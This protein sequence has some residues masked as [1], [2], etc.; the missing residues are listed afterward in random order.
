MNLDRDSLLSLAEKPLKPK[1]VNTA[2][3]TVYTPLMNAKEL[4][5]FLD[6]I[7]GKNSQEMLHLV[8]DQYGQRV[9]KESDVE[10]VER[11]PAA[12]TVPVTR[13]FREANGLVPKAS[14]SIDDSP[15]GSP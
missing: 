13:A 4:A 3:G 14:V 6:A 12:F 10:H 7:D 1:Q 9:F 5:V 8:V 2:Y 11:L 15:T